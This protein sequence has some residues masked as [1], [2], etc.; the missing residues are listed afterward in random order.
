MSDILIHSAGKGWEEKGRGGTESVGSTD[1]R[2]S[3]DLGKFREVGH[4]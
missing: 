2:E 3:G 4:C 1:G